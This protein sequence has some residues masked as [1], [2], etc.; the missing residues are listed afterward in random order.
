MKK[1]VGIISKLYLQI[2]ALA[3]AAPALAV[4][5]PPSE[6]LESGQ[7]K[8]ILAGVVD[9]VAGLAGIIA[10]LFLVYGGIMYMV[11]GP[12]GNETGRGIITNALIGLAVVV[13]SYLIVKFL[14]SALGVGG[15][16]FT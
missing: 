16:S 6:P 10:V 2:V 15:G 12:K 3:L 13:L 5:V 9:V 11:G 1:F 4:P 7:L 14:L 8:T